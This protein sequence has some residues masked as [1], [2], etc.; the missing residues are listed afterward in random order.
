MKIPHLL[1]ASVLVTGAAHA[2][3]ATSRVLTLDAARRIAAAAAVEGQH[4]AGGELSVRGTGDE[5]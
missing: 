1:A 5:D 4:P 2:Q 3:L